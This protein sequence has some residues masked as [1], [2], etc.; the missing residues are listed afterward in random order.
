MISRQCMISKARHILTKHILFL[1][2]V[3]NRTFK[4]NILLLK[5]SLQFSSRIFHIDSI[6][7]ALDLLIEFLNSDDALYRAVIIVPMERPYKYLH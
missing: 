5:Y 4:P 7:I 1:L 3:L 6:L 2:C